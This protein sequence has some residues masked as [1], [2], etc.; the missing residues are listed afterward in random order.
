MSLYKCRMC[1]KELKAEAGQFLCVCS[2]CG[3][4]QTLPVSDE[5]DITVMLNRGNHLRQLC[6]FDRAAAVYKE[7]LGHIQNDPE[8]YWQL[9]LCRY[10]IRYKADRQIG[11]MIPECRKAR[12]KSILCD[13]SFLDAVNK[14]DPLRRDAYCKEAE[15]ID[16]MQK[17]LLCNAERLTENDA[18]CKD[19]AEYTLNAEDLI[20]RGNLCL[21]KRKWAA[22]DNYFNRAIDA[23]P[24]EP[25]AYFG[26]LLV[27]CE[28]GDPSKIPELKCDLS[29]SS[30]YRT[31][32]RLG[33]PELEALNKQS[34]F[35]RAVQLMNDARNAEELTMARA[36]FS[37]SGNCENAG[38]MIEECIRRAE[39]FK[40]DDYLKACR[41]LA[42]S[43]TFEETEAARNIFIKLENYKDSPVK[44]REC[45]DLLIRNDYALEEE[46]KKGINMLDNAEFHSDYDNISRIFSSLGNYRD[47]SGMLKKCLLKRRML[48]FSIVV[49]I[50]FIAGV[51][52]AAPWLIEKI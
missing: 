21:E 15:Y 23:E 38:M 28:L 7:L 51:C 48:S 13:Q 34:I 36:L 10:G 6:E 17:K 5:D 8:I 35:N 45:A 39:A 14:S 18:S 30:N 20:R 42:D 16:V 46:Y 25:A 1:E 9:A 44:V 37:Q 11:F 27:E 22:A 2:F 41:M 47:S 4:S 19:A 43:K 32:V 31:A 49:K 26:K 50:M 3:T 29:F 24:N 33:C 40:K 12:Y 52:C